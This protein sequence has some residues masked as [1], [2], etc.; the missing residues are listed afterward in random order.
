MLKINIQG[1]GDLELSDLILDL[2]G[3]L[4]QNGVLSPEV[5]DAILQLKSIL[6]I[7]LITA[8]TYGT[9][10][11]IA[12]ELAIHLYRLNMSETESQQKAALIL[13]FEKNHCCAIG[14]G[15][16]DRF[17]L[18][19]A[20]LG[21]AIIGSEGAAGE[22]IQNADLCVCNILDALHLLLYPQILKATLR[23]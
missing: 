23:D 14:N 2:N 10:S 19:E 21:I 6:N 11:K 15:R 5:K 7:H 8:D 17:M 16:N 13:K 9:A 1:F 18:Q 12:D 4:T 22:T 3:T 20:R